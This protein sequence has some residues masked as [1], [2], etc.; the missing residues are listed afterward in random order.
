MNRITRFLVLPAL[1]LALLSGCTPS[2]QTPPTVAPAPTSAPAALPPPTVAPVQPTVAPTRALAPTSAATPT[3]VAIAE[4]LDAL[5][6]G[7]AASG[8]FSGAVLIVDGDTVVLRKGYGA[9]DAAT[10]TANAPETS[11]RIGGLSKP[12]TAAAILLLEAQ[13]KLSVTDPICAYLDDCPPAW[14]PV[15]LHHLLSNTS[16]IENYTVEDR[17]ASYSPVALL[18]S[19]RDE[20]L[21]F[22]PGEGFALSQTNYVLLGMVIERASG[23]PYGTFMEEQ[24][25]A[26]LGM[27]ATGY[28]GQ[29]EGLATGYQGPRSAGPFEPSVGYAAYGLYSTV[30]DL[31]RFDQA[32]L[33]GGLLPAE[34]RAKLVASHLELGE[35][36]AGYGVLRS[37][38][39]Y[40][41]HQI[42]GL[43]LAVKDEA[44]YGVYPGYDS[45]NYSLTDRGIYVVILANNERAAVAE[46][47]EPVARM[48]LGE[49]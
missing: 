6:T 23:Q 16:G 13:G 30:D 34:Q 41:G 5:F 4:R 32:I 15:T 10:G 28:E 47:V 1:A 46:L 40:A 25:F 39:Y 42:V 19:V 22:A 18:E 8:S 33:A 38:T 20:P 3:T 48:L 26:P 35:F 43:G 14:E 17:A 12:L 36:S 2:V 11:F 21:A 7:Q 24:I 37:D 9:A 45:I 31:Y 49:I 27:S 44:P 29:P